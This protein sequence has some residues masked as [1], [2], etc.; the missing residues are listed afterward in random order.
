MKNEVQLWGERS[1]ALYP[2]M[3]KMR[4][5]WEF[6]YLSPK[7]DETYHLEVLEIARLQKR[8]M[9]A[10]ASLKRGLLRSVYIKIVRN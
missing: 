5:R 9:E 6:P 1:L 3:R 2:L 8:A 10:L 4:S 7:V